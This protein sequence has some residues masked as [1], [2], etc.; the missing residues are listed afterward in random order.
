MNCITSSRAQVTFLIG[1]FEC[2]GVG[3]RPEAQKCS[4]RAH[5]VSVYLLV[6]LQLCVVDLSDL[7]EFGSVVR[8]FD[9]VV[10][11]STRGHCR[12]CSS[13]GS[14]AFLRP[15]HALCQQH[16]VQ[17]HELGVWRILLLGTTDAETCSNT[18]KENKGS[19]R[20]VQEQHGDGG[21]ETH[22]RTTLVR[23]MWISVFLQVWSGC[24]LFMNCAAVAQV[25]GCS[26]LFTHTALHTPADMTATSINWQMLNGEVALVLCE[27]MLN[28]KLYLQK[29]SAALTHGCSKTC[30]QPF[31]CCIILLR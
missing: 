7:G 22:K 26:L 23:G 11:G 29:A 19:G 16:V 8:M 10:C 3:K 14:A 24:L 21:T 5:D 12:S 2:S 9:G 13:C 15:G 18:H 4:V 1:T 27:R 25:S 6:F 20:A 28:R 31:K 30:F 17:A